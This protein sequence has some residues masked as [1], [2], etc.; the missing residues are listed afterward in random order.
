MN[1]TIK[2]SMI[3]FTARSFASSM[4][5][6]PCVR[7]YVYQKCLRVLPKLLNAASR[8]QGR[9]IGHELWFSDAKGLVKYEWVTPNGRQMPVGF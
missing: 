2:I 6:C 3:I 7:P 9:T 8:K 4:C 5:C 1:D